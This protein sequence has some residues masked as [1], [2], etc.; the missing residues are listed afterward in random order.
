MNPSYDHGHQ[1]DGL[2]KTLA[3]KSLRLEAA[4][5]I[6]QKTAY[7]TSTVAFMLGVTTAW[8]VSGREDF[9]MSHLWGMAGA[10]VAIY[11]AQ[12]WWARRRLNRD[13]KNFQDAKTW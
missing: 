7:I 12:I 3:A 6:Q 8:L 9:P 5:D 10:V 13:L 2:T 11:V 1:Y 4:A